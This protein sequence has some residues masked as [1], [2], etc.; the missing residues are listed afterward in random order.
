MIVEEIGN[1]KGHPRT[2]FPKHEPDLE[3]RVPYPVPVMTWGSVKSTQ[4]RL[5]CGKPTNPENWDPISFSQ[6]GPDK[7]LGPGWS[8]FGDQTAR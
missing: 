4:Q 5:K 7:L 2:T 6:S 8:S 3:N 1:L